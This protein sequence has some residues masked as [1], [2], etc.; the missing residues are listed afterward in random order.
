MNSL[1]KANVILQQANIPSELNIKWQALLAE[2]KTYPSAVVAF[3]GGVD[4]SFLAYSAF[5]VLGEKML[6]ITIQSSVESSEQIDIARDFAAKNGFRHV[7]ISYEPLQD[8]QFKANPID[9]CYICKTAILHTIW[10]YAHQ[11]NLQVVI[12]GQNA[13]DQGDY[14]PGQKAVVEA[15]AYS[16]LAKSGLAKADIRWLAKALGLSIWDMP[17]SPCLAT[18]FPYGTTITEV[19]LKQ[20][21]DGE[22]FLHAKGYKIVRVRYHHELARIEVSPEQIEQ[23]VK[24]REEIVRYFKQIGFLFVSLDLQGYRLGSL[25][26]GLQ[27]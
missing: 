19:G 7:V 23:L 13:S 27:L 15:G 16:P 6:A 9:R 26:E 10:E 24:D 5:L 2:L 1:E 22:A 17:S 20:I 21:A 18:R 4:S 8:P 12:E 3:S 14:R 25:N 11:N